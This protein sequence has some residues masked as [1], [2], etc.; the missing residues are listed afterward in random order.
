MLEEIANLGFHWAELHEGLGPCPMSEIAKF[1]DQGGI[2]ISHLRNYC[3]S[4]LN[5]VRGPEFTAQEEEERT[6]AV[7]LT[8]RTIDHAIQLGASTVVLD[9]G[10]AMDMK[11]HSRFL[12]LACQGKL[13]TKEF[14]HAKIE[15][16]LQR[17]KKSDL[18]KNRVL[19]C[20]REVGDYAGDRGIRLG[21][22]NQEA[23]EAFPSERE[24]PSLLEELN[25]PVFGYWHNFGSAQIKQYLT[26]LD[27]EQWLKC[28]VSQTIGCSL[29]DVRGLDQRHLPPF[30]GVIDYEKLVPLLPHNSLFVLD[31]RGGSENAA[32]LSSIEHWKNQFRR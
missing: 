20:L 27:H 6:L 19:D 25:H 26:L 7:C 29:D 16:I 9:C 30:T 11:S 2:H 13:Y 14:A 1:V 12:K 4:P 8:Q 28:M 22:E 17:E 15:E 24:F 21:I 10:N 3:F 31:L 18:L 5:G 23:Y 32:I